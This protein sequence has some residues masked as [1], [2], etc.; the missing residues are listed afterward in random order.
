MQHKRMSQSEL[1]RAIG[2]KPQS[3][4]YLLN[5]AKS[6]AGS[7]HIAAIARALDVSTDWLALGQGSMLDRRFEAQSMTPVQWGAP[8]VDTISSSIEIAVQ[9]V[10]EALLNLPESARPE[11]APLLQALCMAPDSSTLK[12]RLVRALQSAQP[13]NK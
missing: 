2:I 5:P 1:A 8:S 10:A 12:S 7:R 6:A 11:V 13:E 4:Q 3:V 9:S